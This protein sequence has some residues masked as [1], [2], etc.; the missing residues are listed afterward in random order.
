M[1]AGHIGAA[2]AIGRAERRINIGVLV[3]AALLIDFALWLFVLLGWESVVIPADYAQTG[4]L[5]INRTDMSPLGSDQVER[6]LEWV[7]LSNL[8]DG[9]GQLEIVT[10]GNY[11]ESAGVAVYELSG[12]KVEQ[13]LTVGCGV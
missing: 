10:Y 3:F 7:L 2:L 12:G 9:D 13:R 8:L 5:V 4:R 1:F 11:F 6:W